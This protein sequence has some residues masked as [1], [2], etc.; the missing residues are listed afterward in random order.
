MNERDLKKEKERI[1]ERL[2][3]ALLEQNM[4]VGKISR[5]AQIERHQ[6]KGIMTGETNYTVETLMKFA[7]AL[8]LEI[9]LTRKHEIDDFEQIVK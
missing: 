2:N 3:A 9:S 6:G 7:N 1:T 4:T 5:K 8:G